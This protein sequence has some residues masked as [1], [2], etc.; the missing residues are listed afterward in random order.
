MRECL[1]LYEHEEKLLS[2]CSGCMTATGALYFTLSVPLAGVVL[3]ESWGAVIHQATTMLERRWSL[4]SV[5]F[6]IQTKSCFFSFFFPVLP[7]TEM[8]FLV[9]SLLYS[10]KKLGLV[11]KNV[12]SS[13]EKL[14]PLSMN[15]P[16][17]QTTKPQIL[18]LRKI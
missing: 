13:C 1:A 5:V 16:L 3:M 15:E 14:T 11:G 10:S 4:C 6:K 12:T 17:L 8:C 7:N 9:S 2:D 18:A